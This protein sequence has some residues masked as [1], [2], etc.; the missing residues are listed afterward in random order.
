MK[1]GKLKRYSE[2]EL[3]EGLD[4]AGA[5]ADELADISDHEWSG[6]G[7]TALVGSVKKY[8]RPTEPV[9]EDDWEANS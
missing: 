5:H 4:S 2:N 1:V 3:L 7:K 6:R 9:G 8:D